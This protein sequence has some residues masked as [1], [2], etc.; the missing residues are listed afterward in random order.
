MPAGDRPEGEALVEAALMEW[1]R[2]LGWET[3]P[4][5]LVAP[6]EALAERDDYQ[7]VIL[8][9]RLRAALARLNPDAPPAALDE[10]HRILVR[11]PTAALLSANR[12]F[13][14]RLV[15]GVEVDLLGPQSGVR[16]HLVRIVDFERP[17]RNDWLAVNQFTVARTPPPHR[18]FD[19]VLFVNGLPLIV[20]ELKRPDDPEATIWTAFEQ[21]RTYEEEL[22]AFF[23]RN[24]L[25]VVSDGVDARLGC[26]GSTREWFHRWRTVDGTA[27]ASSGEN[28]LEVLARGVF[29]HE[30][31]CDLVRHFVVFDDR[32][33]RFSKK[34]AGYHQFHA[35]RKAVA[36]TVSAAGP[37]GDRRAGVIWHTQGSG[38]SLTMAFYAGKLVVTRELANPTI[39]VITDR[40]DLDD[41]LFGT[42]T[43]CQD[44]LRQRP[45]Q[46]RDRAHLREL[47]QVGSGGVVFTT[48]QKFFPD[49]PH[50]RLPAL[51]DR[52]NVVVIADEAHRSQ[53]GFIDGF[54]RHLRDA[55]PGAAF[56]A[57][58]GTPV[59]LEDRDTRLTFGDY[60]DV[61]DIERAVE[62][63][64]TVRIYYESRLARLDLDERERP[65]IDPEFEEVTEGEDEER[66][67]RLKSK[68]AQLEAVVGTEK[69][70]ALVARDL[71]D[72][73]ERRLEA[74]DGKAMVVCMSRRICID[75]HD[76]IARLRPGWHA[77][78]DGEGRLKVVMTGS[79]SDPAGWQRHI[80]NDARRKVLARR[81]RDPGDEFGL[82]I[83]RDMWLTG[84]DAPILHTMY[85]DK[86]MRGH[87]LMQA[88]A[89]VNRVFRD[90]PGGLVVD[91]IGIA[92]NLRRALV[93]YTESGGRGRPTIDQQDAVTAMLERCEICRD[94][95]WGFDYS[96]WI[97]GMA[98][99]RMRLVPRAQDHL[100]AQPEGAERFAKAVTELSKTFALSVP[101]PEAEAIRDEVA[102]FQ[103]VKVGLTKTA[104]A[105]LR[106]EEELDHAVRQ[107]VA[108]AIAPKGVIDVFEAAGLPK[109]DISILS[110]E[111]LA[112]VQGMP[113]RHL[114][115]ELLRTLLE[116]ELKQRLRRNVVQSRAFSDMLADAIQRYEART[117]ETAQV[118]EELIELAKR[119]RAAERRGEEMGLS[120]SELAF[121][122]AL[123]TSESAV[124]VLGDS[125]LRT[126]ARELTDTVRRSATI[127]W[128][129]KESVQAR[130]RV[131][132]R[133]ILREYGYP[134]DK[135]ERAVS[136]VLEQARQLGMEFTETAPVPESSVV[137]QPFR[138]VAPDEAR[139]Y[140]NCIPLYSLRAAA[141]A[142]GTGREV[143]AEAWVA[144]H[145]RTAPA[146]GVF[147]AQV[148][149]ES[150]N[151]RIPNGAF[152]VF[153]APVVGSRQG[154]VLLVQ[155]H[156]IADP[157]TGGSYTV[158]LYESSRE[159][160]GDGSWRH[161]EIRLR[162]DT[163]A[164]GYEPIVL[165]GDADD[166]RVVAELIEVLPGAGDNAHGRA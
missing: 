62:D 57:F 97:T 107:I 78:D 108:G 19:V 105:R 21:L 158:K 83:V 68:W 91:Y 93:D 47:L 24:E 76:H 13:H 49:E 114:A 113:Q 126:I 109:P 119:M 122:D 118:V 117:I 10:A 34:V 120:E 18:R 64:A 134:P 82:V 42:F 50:G 162:P 164:P 138:I 141:G 160:D 154:R 46:A 128:T 3:V 36:T 131:M 143:E 101:L 153:R 53:Y 33:E 32:D 123:E 116:G 159:T 37:G 67:R 56:V 85:V 35:T 14:R 80:R 77:D 27:L 20:V 94:L 65:H 124:S 89:R 23:A 130:L 29:E 1:L 150:M 127:D 96:S 157:D 45:V 75:L 9:R 112:E 121:Y 73:F 99:E 163:D 58:T 74:M 147:V 81:F 59:E 95:L 6:G 26:L 39:V 144:P 79:A 30:R 51:S 87:S 7:E 25:L 110:Q 161:S 139:P 61:Y 115:V 136:T 40:N 86:P 90:K 5:S 31:L 125:T 16:G 43:A 88:I 4:G 69:R 66:V 98:A 52:R 84:F 48:I 135:Q 63:G 165:G 133:R 132:I 17:E 41:Q 142:F 55:L 2:D 8:A 54:A 111:F 71:V 156:D 102:F 15:D 38:K 44:L 166:L 129:L 137:A 11:S 145:G 12:D 155:H 151:R 72:H 22:P 60:I 152:C 106:R 92:D 103:T 148:V 28:V 149:G 146:S 140:E 70:L 100:V 104:A